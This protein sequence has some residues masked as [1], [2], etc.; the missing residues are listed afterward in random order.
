MYSDAAG[1][2]EAGM[3]SLNEY[4]TLQNRTVA[5]FGAFTARVEDDQL[6][7]YIGKRDD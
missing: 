5:Q 2:V 1:V 6:I 7:T 4:E 3:V